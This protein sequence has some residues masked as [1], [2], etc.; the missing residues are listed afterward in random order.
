M[1]F[2]GVVDVGMGEEVQLSLQ[3]MEIEDVCYY[4]YFETKFVLMSVCHFHLHCP[5]DCRKFPVH[6]LAPLITGRI[7]TRMDRNMG[8]NDSQVHF[9][10]PRAS[11]S[12]S[13]CREG[14][15]VCRRH[16]CRSKGS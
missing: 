1:T 9:Q 2:I 12:G 4:K 5:V 11:T 3:Y 15:F 10:H 14:L 13:R 8:H 16:P 7:K 6:Q